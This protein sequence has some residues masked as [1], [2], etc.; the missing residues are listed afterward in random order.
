MVRVRSVSKGSIAQEIGIVPGTELVSVNGRDLHDFLD[1]EFLSA[2]E[3]FVLLATMPDGESVEFDIER[4][5]EHEPMGIE[6]DPP[7]IRR[8]ANRCDFCFVDGL[9]EGMRQTLYI[10]DDDYRLSF[11]HGNFAT[12]TNLKSWDI[13]R[14]KEYRLSPLYVSVH[15]TDPVARRRLLRN[16]LAPDVLEQ[17]K[18]FA[19]A[20]IQFHTQIVLQPGVNDGAVLEQ[21][22]SDLY[23]LGET[24]L[25]VSA[26][27]V[28]L[29][30]F[31]KVHLVREATIEENRSVAELLDRV[32]ARALAERGYHWVYGSDDLY[33][34]AEL[35][36]PD[37]SRYDDFE[38]VENGVGAVRFLQDRLESSTMR[39]LSGKHVGI[40]TGMAMKKSMPMVTETLERTTGA[41]SASIPWRTVYLVA[42]LPRPDY[43]PER[44]WLNRSARP[45]TL[46]CF[47]FRPSH[48]MT[49]TC[50]ST[51]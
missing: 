5:E 22:L 2:E 11:R 47:S 36:L 51:T 7:S 30:E 24:V 20:G 46:I 8:C 43:C 45:T 28:G 21:S 26:V 31:S 9:P 41:A 3:E 40:I 16:P 27:P 19:S 12:M 25:S 44:R 13:E 15:S 23:E 32:A 38:Q 4:P 18:D 50:S 39:D 34:N 37:A 48:S 42:V 17:M 49:T 33:I 29:T 6:L 1:W 14:I 35:D 10:R